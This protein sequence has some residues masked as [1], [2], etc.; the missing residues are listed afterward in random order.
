MT[1]TPEQRCDPD[2]QVRKKETQMVRAEGTMTVS[3]DGPPSRVAAVLRGLGRLAGTFVLS[4]RAPRPII[5]RT[6]AG[7]TCCRSRR[8]R[9]VSLPAHRAG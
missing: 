7:V 4:D 6:S 2:T 9:R 1:Y 3:D 5:R 8:V